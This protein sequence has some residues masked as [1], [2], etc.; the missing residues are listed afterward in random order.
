[1]RRPSNR[2]VA[3]GLIV[4]LSLVGGTATLVGG[5]RAASDHARIFT[6]AASSLDPAAQGDVTS[7]SISAQLFET[8][9]TFD[10]ELH[11]QPALAESWRVEDAGTRVVFHLRPGLTFSDGT[12]LRASDVVRSWLRLIDPA[13]PSPLA[14]LMFAVQGASAYMAGTGEASAVGLVADDAT[15]DVTV[16]LAR[17]AS[18]FPDIVAGASF[19][20]VP[21]TVG[22][23]GAFA[24]GLDFV[25]S[26]GYTAVGASGADL[27]LRANDRYWAGRPAIG[28]LDLVGDLGGRSE[29]EVF[30]DGDLDYAPISSFDA[31]WIAYDPKLGPQ[32]REV[33]TMSV[34][35]YGFDTRRAPFDDV[36]VRQAFGMAVDWRRIARLGSYEGESVVANSMVPPGVPGRSERDFLPAYDPVAARALLTEAGYPGGAGFPTVTMQTS[37]GTF[38][39]AIVDEIR[40]ELGIELAT[41]TMDFEAYFDRLEE[42]PPAIWSLSWIADYPGRN[43]FLGVLLASDSTNDYGG[44]SS[45]AFDAAIADAT[46]SNDPATTTAA[47]DRA[48][49]V[50]Q[51]DVPVVP[52][53]YGTGWALS[54]TG[55]LGA[56]QGGL[57]IMRMAGLAWSD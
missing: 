11:L 55:L 3:F 10:S 38:D 13:A 21:S 19:G 35:Y 7:A 50:V 12:P 49:A 28:T 6:G 52:V 42:D 18:D 20:I 17:P 2:A 41:E 36:R 4:S 37:G 31:S 1:M 48:E 26:G 32:L 51:S 57:G 53:A 44:W 39:A 40:R 27:T 9:T 14:S 33:P 43:D 34:E 56:G 54:R 16:T 25:A 15:G 24:P 46:A 30:E 47:Y 8:L 29:V 22:G 45:D 5:A 23:P